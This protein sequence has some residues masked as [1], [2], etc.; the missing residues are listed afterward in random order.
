MYVVFIG[1]GGH[2]SGGFYRYIH[3]PFP[4][5]IHPSNRRIQ[6]SQRG[7]PISSLP[8][9]TKVGRMI[10]LAPAEEEEGEDVPEVEE[11]VI[12]VSNNRRV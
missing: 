10:T 9:E 6:P 4:S 12:L 11:G 2:G 3:I 8:R 7:F 5:S 1:P